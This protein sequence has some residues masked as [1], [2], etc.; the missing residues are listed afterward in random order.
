MF[1]CSVSSGVAPVFRRCSVFRSSVFWCSW[2]YSMSFWR[3][4][5]RQIHTERTVLESFSIKLQ[6]FSLKLHW[7]RSSGTG[8][9]FVILRMLSQASFSI[10]SDFLQTFKNFN[11]FRKNPAKFHVMSRRKVCSHEATA[12]SFVFARYGFPNTWY[13]L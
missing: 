3:W 12:R 10:F 2:F 9:F 5:E 1:C 7:K 6:G 4:K 13:F 8:A 11:Q